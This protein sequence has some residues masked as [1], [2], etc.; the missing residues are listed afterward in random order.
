MLVGDRVD[1][2]PAGSQFD[3]ETGTLVWQPGVGFAGRYDFVFT[4]GEEQFP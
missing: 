1:T 2:L 4:R 3:I